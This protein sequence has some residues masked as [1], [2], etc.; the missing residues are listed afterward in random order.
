M[1][2]LAEG[3]KEADFFLSPQTPLEWVLCAWDAV[4]KEASVQLQNGT[5][6]CEA[7]RNGFLLFVLLKVAKLLQGA[8]FNVF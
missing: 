8:E 6:F 3:L 7:C 5:E 2:N 1:L 4:C